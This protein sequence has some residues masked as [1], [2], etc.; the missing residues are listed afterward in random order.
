MTIIFLT[1][2]LST[3]K[4]LGCEGIFNDRFIANL[5]QSVLVKKNWKSVNIWCSY[6]TK[7]RWLTFLTIL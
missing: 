7:T 1:F 2:F 4:R 6:T 3:E 5:L